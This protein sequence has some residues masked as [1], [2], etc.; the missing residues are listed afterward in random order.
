MNISPSELTKDDPIFSERI[1]SDVEL[2][3]HQLVCLKRCIQLENEPIEMNSAEYMCVKSNIG[4]LGDKV[5]SGKSYVILALVMMNKTPLNTYNKQNVF[6]QYSSI[7][8]EY[9]RPTLN[10]LNTNIIVCSFGLIDQWENYIKTFNKRFNYKIINNHVKLS[11]FTKSKNIEYDILLVSSSFYKFVQSNFKERQI[12]VLRTIFD[13][14]DTTVTPS[15]KQIP[16]DFYWFITASYKNLVNPYPN[17]RQI[18]LNRELST[19]ST[20][21]NNGIVKNVFI[22]TLIVSLLRTLPVTDYP[23]LGNIIIKN[24]DLFVKESFSLPEINSSCIECMDTISEIVKSMTNNTNIINSVNAGDFETAISFINKKHNNC[25]ENTIIN[26]LKQN[27]EKDIQNCKAKKQYYNSIVVEDMEQHEKRLQQLET[28]EKE[29]TLKID[30]LTERIKNGDICCIC[31]DHVNTKTV[32]K[33]CGNS[34]CLECICR[35]LK[36]KNTCPLCKMNVK[37]FSDSLIVVNDKHIKNES[38]RIYNKL[39]T[40]KLLLKKIRLE[41]EKSKILIFSEYEKP[42]DKFV[43]ILDELKIKYGILKG[44]SLKSNLNM[45]R[46]HDVDVLLINSRAFGSGVN[47][48]NTTDII[49][50]HFFNLEIEKQVIGRAQ[51]PGRTRSLNTWYLFNKDEMNRNKFRSLK[52]ATL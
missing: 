45:Y 27:I 37:E 22:K 30:Y 41:N 1:E 51:R 17:H 12:S 34:F 28:Y 38:T 3:T 32:I 25:D 52:C 6:G 20:N 15:A 23:I 33:C 26:L 21:F 9:N 31:Y 50:Y 46:N 19:T 43:D 24:D 8:I 16:S 49:I 29:L 18:W 7:Y 4:I 11:E 39:Y 2:K 13:E 5:G 48:E 44:T 35:W 40:L 42:F 47:L 36:I 14:A 10:R